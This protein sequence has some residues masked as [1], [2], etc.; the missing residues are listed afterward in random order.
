VSIRKLALVFLATIVVAAGFSRLVLGSAPA[1]RMYLHQVVCHDMGTG[2][3]ARA[4]VEFIYRWDRGSN[5]VAH[6][7]IFEEPQ[8]ASSNQVACNDMPWGMTAGYVHLFEELGEPKMTAIIEYLERF[9]RPLPANG[10]LAW[11]D[12]EAGAGNTAPQPQPVAPTCGAAGTAHAGYNCMSRQQAAAGN[13]PIFNGQTNC[14]SGSSDTMVCAGPTP[15]SANPPTPSHNRCVGGVGVQ[16]GNEQGLINCITNPV[17][18]LA[19]M[20]E[21]NRVVIT[22]TLV[23]GT[24]VT[25]ILGMANPTQQICVNRVR[26]IAALLGSQDLARPEPYETQVDVRGTVTTT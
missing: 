25:G 24:Q 6:T 16:I 4:K 8:T 1:G 9:G 18:A 23:N 7:H 14:G 26:N 22:A 10:V 12:F 20:P 11:W 21:A 19:C 15:S 13:R 3:G 5:D 2:R 17:R